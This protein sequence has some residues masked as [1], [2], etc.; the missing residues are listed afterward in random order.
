MEAQPEHCERA[1]LPVVG[2]VPKSLAIERDPGVRPC[3]EGVVALEDPFRARRRK[4]SIADQQAEAAMGKKI[5]PRCG[6]AVPH[7][8][9]SQSVIG[10]APRA[11]TQR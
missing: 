11:P 5:L 7:R 8:S 6:E 1:S 2:R 9:H 4:P 3:L 10:T